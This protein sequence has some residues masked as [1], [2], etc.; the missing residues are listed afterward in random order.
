MSNISLNCTA[1]AVLFCCQK[2]VV[3]LEE[4]NW[5]IFLPL[6]LFILVLM[7]ASGIIFK[8][9]FYPI[10]DSIKNV[11]YIIKLFFNS[12]KNELKKINDR[13]NNRKH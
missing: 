11:A 4:V 13:A 2:E 9:P 5:A 3:I 12:F 8:N 10:I 1:Q 6:T 7:L